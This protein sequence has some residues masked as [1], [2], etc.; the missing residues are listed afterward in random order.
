[1]YQVKYLDSLQLDLIQAEDYLFQYSAS[2]A[3]RLNDDLYSKTSVL[4]ENPYIY[5]VYAPNPRFRFIP[6]SYEYLCFYVVNEDKKQLE[7]RRLIRGMRNI[8][9]WLE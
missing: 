4:P 5:P 9:R 2:A 8:P 1:M 3:D 6:L 7:V